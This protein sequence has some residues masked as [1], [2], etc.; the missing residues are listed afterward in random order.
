MTNEES[1][2]VSVLLNDGQGGF[3]PP[4]SY[5]VG[6]S[7]TS[8]AAGDL[9][10]DGFLDLAV[11]NSGAGDI[12]VLLNGKDGSFRES[13]RHQVQG[14]AY[15]VV[16]ADLDGDGDLDLATGSLLCFLNRGNGAFDD[17]V[18]FGIGGN[19]FST[20]AGDLDRDG[21]T[22]LVSATG[23]YLSIRF[24]FTTDAR[25]R[26]ADGDAV[27]DECAASPPFRRGDVNADGRLSVTDPIELLRRTFQGLPPPPC[28][29]AS[30]ANDD[31]EA[32]AADAIAILQFLFLGGGSFPPP[33]PACGSDP[34]PDQLGCAEG[35]R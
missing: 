22:D 1:S 19:A 5:E 25:S 28:L 18:S 26:D 30:D 14:T 10:G 16:A 27:P 15:Y 24:N 29:E 8:V 34:T 35:C 31:G 7:P 23:T 12:T 13:E 11:T 17:P 4:R 3:S 2:D 21:D 6:A 32:G 9:D 33:G 20:F